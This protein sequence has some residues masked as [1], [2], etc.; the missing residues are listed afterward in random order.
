MNLIDYSGDKS[1]ALLASSTSIYYLSLHS[2]LL[3]GLK[4]KVSTLDIL[5][6][7]S[8][9][10]VS[11]STESEITSRESFQYV[12]AGTAAPILV[13]TDKAFESLKINILGS[14][15][16]D[17][18]KIAGKGAE[19]ILGMT[20]HG[21]R[22]ASAQSHF[23]V[24]Y[25]NAQ[26]HWAEV[27]HVNVATGSTKKAYELPKLG[28]CGA[29][30][31]STLDANVYFTR[32]TAFEVIITSSVSHGVLG[33]YAIRPKSHGGLTD[34]E[35]VLHAVSEVVSKDSSSFS[36]RSALTLSSG[37]LELVRNGDTVWVRPESLTGVI[38]VAWA[39]VPSE[40]DLAKELFVESHDNVLAAY[41]HRVKRHVRDL[42]YFPAW[43]QALPLRVFGGFLGTE[44]QSQDQTLQRDS[45]GFRKI[46]I[47][48]TEKGRVHALDVGMQ[49]RI[50]WSVQAASIQ[51]GKKWNLTRIVVDDASVTIL[52]EKGVSVAIDL[53]TGQ[54]SLRENNL[55]SETTGFLVPISSTRGSEFISIDDDGNLEDPSIAR[56]IGNNTV[57]VTR[58]RS[59]P[60]LGWKLHESRQ[61]LL[62]WEFSPAPGEK[63]TGVTTRPAHDPVASIGKA[64][65]DRNVLYKYLSSNLLLIT[66][67]CAATSTAS[68]YL[69]DSITGQILYTATHSGVDTSQV[70]PATFVE[71]WFAYSIFSDPSPSAAADVSFPLHKSYQLIITELYESPIRNDR[72]PLGSSAY[73][74]S[75]DTLPQPHA[76]SATYVIPAAISYLT[77][78]STNQG[79]TPRALL[80]TLPSL[81]ALVS[82]PL[83]FLSPRR[84]VGRD[85]T[86]AEQE[87]G[88]FRYAPVLDFNPQWMVNHKREIF[89]IKAVSTVPTNMESTS[90]IVAWGEIDLFGTRISP[91]GSFDTLG[92][93]F[94]RVQLL[95]TVL[96]LGVGTAVLAPMVRK[97]MVNG[98]WIT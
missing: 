16:I 10:Q 55:S 84:P 20:A 24:H 75:L 4:T 57:L 90:A 33:R 77:T 5:T 93:G 51:E 32:N 8:K 44:P 97:K 52:V 85:P 34:P 2:T 49:G 13:W 30:S 63:I 92:R 98:L 28:G 41:I 54:T 66:A 96:A 81:N 50:L 83:P 19:D 70:I 27:Y 23:L 31:T 68:L 17:T 73:V 3:T 47:V 11:L 78:T 15:H 62:A 53:L 39:E 56:L 36:V 9:A 59:G 40:K 60:I 25:Q 71:N 14:K 61:P 94:S 95:G 29:F 87:E 7:K 72:G 22:T 26:S 35:G 45:F 1:G 43:A 6:G 42:R 82:I 64:L 21:P 69:L 67:I 88:L 65:G 12:G 79:I 37:D 91:I 46:L 18:I 80:A 89:G 76:I 48:A 58:R 74:S 86:P 38:A